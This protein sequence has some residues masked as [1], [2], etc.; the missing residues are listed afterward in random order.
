MSEV[1]FLSKTLS[2]V[3]LL[4][5]SSF[6]YILSK[7]IN[8]MYTVMLVFIGILLVPLSNTALFGFIDDFRLTPNVLFFVFLPVLLFE[9][10][11][12]INYRNLLR[13]WKAIS[14]L[15]VLGLFISSIVIAGSLYFILPLV[16]LHIPFLVCF[17]FWA[18]ISATDPVAV[19][20]TF[21]KV[22]APRRLTML[23]EWE[24]LFNDGTSVALFV[25]I[26]GV[27]L[28]WWVVSGVT[29]LQWWWEFISM[30]F[31]GIIFWIF[32]WVLFSKVIGYIKNNEEVEIVLTIV[33]AH[34]TFIMAEVITRYFPFL[35]ISWVIATVV[36]SIIIWN[37]GRYK[38]T[39]KVEAHMQKFWEFF[40]FIS[41]SLV[42]ILMGLI[43]SS[44]EIAV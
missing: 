24:S 6:T 15:A 23:F 5:I 18:L 13:N 9:W 4:I 8:F 31:G 33:L 27:I 16:W 37:Y 41:N 22:W 21:K 17:L 20:A 25:V 26:L 39:P 34:F 14:S 35:P 12:N 38:I 11:Y 1:T 19:L 44:I 3:V 43:L 32:T 7:R 29:Y 30:L 40:A 36:A 42:F 2:L 10:A 28:E